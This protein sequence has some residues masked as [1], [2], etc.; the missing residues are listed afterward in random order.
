LQVFFF[1]CFYFSD[2]TECHL[3]FEQKTL[4]P[5]S[6]GGVAGGEKYIVSG[7]LFKFAIDHYGLYAGGMILF[8]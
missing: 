2:N 6:V 7:I 4:K 5:V 3:P 8:D 1:F